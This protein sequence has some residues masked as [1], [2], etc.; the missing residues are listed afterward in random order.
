M[1]N[2][3]V[4]GVLFLTLLALTAL[5]FLPDTQVE[6]IQ[7]IL[8]RYPGIDKLFHFVEHIFIV[9]VVF[10]IVRLLPINLPKFL[11]IS[12]ALGFSFLF[13][14]T[15]EIHQ[16]YTSGR[17]FEYLD[18]LAN[19]LGSLTA[20]T[21][22][23]R[24]ILKPWLSVLLLSLLLCSASVLTYKSYA[25]QK[26]F[27]QGMH[28]EKNQEYRKAK[29][30][31]LLALKAGYTSAGL[32]NTIAWL[33]LEYLEEDPQIAYE[34]AQKAVELAP[35]NAD[36]L[37]TYGWALFS[38]NKPR[39]AIH[40]LKKAYLLNPDIYCIDYHLGMTYYALGEKDMAL[41]HLKK[42]IDAGDK[43]YGLSA[44]KALNKIND[45]MNSTLFPEDVNN[46]N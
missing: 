12:I 26:Y 23:M 21:F 14:I 11:H 38:L 18:L 28:Y 46:E 17:T 10:H 40:F 1:K 22:I 33:Y 5:F 39:T 16:L 6:K 13:S 4:A 44:R 36:Y 31:Y 29:E 25:K 41:I 3:K 19:T 32:F 20:L 45:E 35:N 24:K 15:D 42:Q 27:Y 30:H 43:R 2:K 7:E 8:L 9:L 37:D 34:Y